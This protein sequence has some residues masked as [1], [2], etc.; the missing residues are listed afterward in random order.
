MI[1]NDLVVKLLHDR[2]ILAKTPGVFR[3]MLDGLSV[4]WVLMNE[5]T[6][7]WSPYEIVGHLIHGEKTD[8]IPRARIILEHGEKKPFEPFDRFAHLNATPKKP[9]KKN[10][11]EFEELRE[12]NLKTLDGFKLVQ[13]DLMLKGRHPELGVVTLG[14][15]IST[16]AVHDLSHIAQ[17][18]RVMSKQ[19]ISEVGAWREFLPILDRK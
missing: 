1:K 16:W 14:Q 8:W 5:G 7:T 4:D 9:L 6:L 11:D 19:R 10:L 15:L 12:R 18:A 3:M 2:E 17:A 13:Q